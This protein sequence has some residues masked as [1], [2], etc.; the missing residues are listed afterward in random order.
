MI[1]GSSNPLSDMTGS[2]LEWDVCSAGRTRGSDT[3]GAG[4]LVAS[5]QSSGGASKL[6]QVRGRDAVQEGVRG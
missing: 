5:K 3:V 6:A 1:E 2:A 4:W